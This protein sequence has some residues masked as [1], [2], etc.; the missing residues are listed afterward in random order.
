MHKFVVIKY[1]LQSMTL[2]Q[3]YIVQANSES[4]AYRPYKQLIERLNRT[5]KY[6]VRPA[7]GFASAGQPK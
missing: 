3:I 5:F 6:H 7:G 1:L 2:E 4:E